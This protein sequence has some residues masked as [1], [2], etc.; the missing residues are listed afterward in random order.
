[1]GKGIQVCSNERRH[2]F[3]IEDHSK[4]VKIHQKY[5]KIFFFRTIGSISTRLGTNHLWDKGIQVCSNE[6]QHPSLRG[7]NSKRVKIHKKSFKIFFSRTTW[8]ISTRLSTNHPWGIGFKFDQ[9]KGGT[10]L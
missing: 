9:M 6:G 10:L 1:L 3:L 8:P 7:D 2:P 4:R 5:L